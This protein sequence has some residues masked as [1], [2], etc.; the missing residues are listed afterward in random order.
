MR[1]IAAFCFQQFGSRTNNTIAAES[2]LRKDPDSTKPA[3]TVLALLYVAQPSPPAPTSSMGQPLTIVADCYYVHRNVRTLL[4]FIL[5]K[6]P[7]A[8]GRTNINSQLR[9]LYT[10]KKA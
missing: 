8:S 3:L 2:A 9:P 6:R 1:D 4:A 10:K 7:L 5:P